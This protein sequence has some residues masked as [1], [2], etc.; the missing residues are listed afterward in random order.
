LN[1]RIRERQ[2][3][4]GLLPVQQTVAEAESVLGSDGRVVVR[5]S[6]TEPVVRVMV[7]GPEQGMIE[8]LAH[9]IGQ[10]VANALGRA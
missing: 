10:A 9:R 8:P 6:G 4:L 5:L 7:E 2:D 1:V 3:P